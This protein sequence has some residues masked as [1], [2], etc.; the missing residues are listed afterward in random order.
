MWLVP[1]SC[2]CFRGSEAWSLLFDSPSQDHEWWVTSSGTPMLQPLSWRGWRNRPWIQRLCSSGKFNNWTA[3]NFAVRSISSAA[4]SRASLT[5]LQEINS[6]TKTTGRSGTSSP[7]SSERVDPPW[8][9]SRTFQLSLP[10]EGLDLSER[11]YADWVSNSQIRSSWALETLALRMSARE[12]SSWPTATSTDQ[13][14]SGVSENWTKESGRHSGTT[15]TDAS[16]KWATAT[17]HDGRRPGVEDSSTQGRNLQRE[18]N[19]WEHPKIDRQENGKYPTPSASEYGTNQGG[20]AGRVGEI[21]PSLRTWASSPQAPTTP[22]DGSPRSDERGSSRRRL[23]PAFVSWLMGYPW[24]WMRAEPIN[25]AAPVTR[26]WWR[27]L[28]SHFDNCF[29][30]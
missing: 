18:A 12:S 1:K 25:S 13:K 29:G 26:W 15:L 5:L 27:R 20:A 2:L 14:Q 8:S 21:R 3:A 17:A 24:Y 16:K 11:N 30:G 10:V 6:A 7:A 19:L 9:L 22:S 4:V 28:T 23:N